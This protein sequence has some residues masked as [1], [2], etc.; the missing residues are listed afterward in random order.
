MRH[1][2]RSVVTWMSGGSVFRTPPQ[3]KPSVTNCLAVVG[4]QCSA[5]SARR[6]ECGELDDRWWLYS[7]VLGGLDQNSLGASKGTAVRIG[8]HD[9]L[10]SWNQ[11][12]RGQCH[13]SAAQSVD[14]CPKRGDRWFAAEDLPQSG[15]QC[16]TDDVVRV[17]FADRAEQASTTSCRTVGFR[18]EDLVDSFWPRFE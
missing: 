11:A 6:H 18:S 16:R 10:F 9:K 3:Q 2:F 1:A 7:V 12:W 15:R 8:Q 14:A 4:H 17:E 5:N 13:H